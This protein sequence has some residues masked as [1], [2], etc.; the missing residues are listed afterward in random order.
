M[1]KITEIQQAVMLFSTSSLGKSKN[2]MGEKI[3]EIL[4]QKGINPAC[5][6][7]PFNYYHYW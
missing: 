5:F 6:N 7:P 4:K 2:E 1:N 3:K